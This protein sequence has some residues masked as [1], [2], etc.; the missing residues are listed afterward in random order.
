MLESLNNW[1][2]VIKEAINYY[3]SA[4]AYYHIALSNK[5][6]ACSRVV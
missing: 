4:A 1:K 5:V 6:G 2:I 3:L